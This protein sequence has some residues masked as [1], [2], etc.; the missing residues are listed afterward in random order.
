M[1]GAE[2]SALVCPACDALIG[3]MF[4]SYV[5]AE[6]WTL[7]NAS[8]LNRQQKPELSTGTQTATDLRKGNPR[9]K[10]GQPTSR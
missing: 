10:G 8:L 2:Y 5:R 3:Q 6:K 1:K 4:V 7:V 9:N